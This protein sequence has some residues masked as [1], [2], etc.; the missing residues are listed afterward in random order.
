MADV[1]MNG[2]ALPNS[3]SVLNFNRV[4][5]PM[6]VDQV[7]A[8]AP[9]LKILPARA[10]DSNNFVYT[11]KTANPA[12][13][14]R[15]INS[16]LENTAGSY[17]RVTVDLKY[18]DASFAMDVAA[19]E[20]DDRGVDHVLT[21]EAISHLQSAMASIESQIFYGTGTGGNAD[22]F[23]GFLD[24]SNLDG[25]SDAQVVNAGGTT[26][27]TG[28]STYLIAA[29]TPDLEV[30]W[31]ESGQ[32]SVGPRMKVRNFPGTGVYWQYAH[33]IGTW[34]GLKIGRNQSVVRI[35]NVTEDAGKGLT[36]DL[37]SEAISIFPA[38]LQATH[39]VTGRRSLGQLQQS[40]TATNPTGAPAPF[41]ESAFGIPIV[42]TD[43]LLENEAIIV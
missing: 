7:L 3:Q 4:D 29:G 25:A 18:Y 31:G 9:L 40:R 21:I 5:M 24:Q 34:C 8:H 39:I 32:I 30:L 33:E 36:D 6:L 37:I 38:E 17:S 11:K 20:I 19:A 43:N 42:V 28:Q 12:T 35:A 1:F 14:F 22:G 23:D 27:T 41:P 10:V 16:G 15:D 26:A 13:G 2:T